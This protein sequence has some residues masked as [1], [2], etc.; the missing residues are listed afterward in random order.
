MHL[1]IWIQKLISVPLNIRAVSCKKWIR[2]FLD[3]LHLHHPQI[4]YKFFS[5]GIQSNSNLQDLVLIFFTSFSKVKD[6]KRVWKISKVKN[7]KL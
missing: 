6:I 1:E 2:V 5:W 4:N 7:C 3:L